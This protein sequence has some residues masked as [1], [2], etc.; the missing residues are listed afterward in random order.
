M[1]HKELTIGMPHG[2]Y[3]THLGGLERVFNRERQT[4]FKESPLA[5][6]VDIG[7]F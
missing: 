3:E 5:E 6:T 4:R 7:E 1:I 2:R